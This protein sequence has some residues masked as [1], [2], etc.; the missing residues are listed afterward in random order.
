MMLK[1][2]SIKKIKKR[3]IRMNSLIIV[4][5]I[6]MLAA[7]MVSCTA[8]ENSKRNIEN[9]G[10]NGVTIIKDDITEKATFY[11]YQSGDTY[12]EL[13]AIRA[14]DGTV[15]TAF[16]TCQVC[17]GTGR[18]Y[19]KQDGDVVV[20]QNCGNRFTVDQ[21]EVVKGGC[22]PIPIFKGSKTED[23]ET[24]TIPA[25]YL[26]ENTSLFIDWKS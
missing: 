26:D 9:S 21:I 6:V 4:M 5:A 14:S 15:R 10:S 3:I 8:S 2:K 25:S 1:K 17:Q 19:Y 24:I 18:G 11:P 22:N 13:I 23:N 12:M 16:N 7:T 20:C